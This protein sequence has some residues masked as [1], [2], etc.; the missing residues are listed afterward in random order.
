MAF[1]TTIPFKIMRFLSKVFY[2]S[3]AEMDVSLVV[4]SGVISH[5]IHSFLNHSICWVSYWSNV[6][7]SPC[8]VYSRGSYSPLTGF[9]PTH[10]VTPLKKPLSGL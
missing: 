6:I 3:A 10:V 5:S 9:F 2:M 4:T 7:L 1:L 8:V